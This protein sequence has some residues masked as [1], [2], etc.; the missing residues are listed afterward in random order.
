MFKEKAD[1]WAKAPRHVGGVILLIAAC[2]SATHGHI[3]VAASSPTVTSLV[4]ATKMIIF[5]P[6]GVRGAAVSGSC[7]MGESLALNRADAW[8]CSVG[9]SIYDP[10]FSATTHATTVTCGATPQQPIGFPVKLAQPLPAHGK[11]ADN[12]AWIVKLG[13]GV[14]CAFVTGAT[15]GVSG[16]RANYACSDRDWLLGDL[17]PG[18]V[19]TAVKMTLQTGTSKT[20]PQASDIFLESVETIWK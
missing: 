5:H 2:L 10:C 15:F 3:A 8:R 20:G 19:W 14:Y 18:R 9:N 4:P 6:T 13:D 17:V 1:M 16:Q 12:Q 7:S 11:V